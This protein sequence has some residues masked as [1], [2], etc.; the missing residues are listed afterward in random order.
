MSSVT[1]V[2]IDSDSAVILARIVST[3]ERLLGSNGGTC[4]VKI[5]PS[6]FLADC[7]AWMRSRQGQSWAIQVDGRAVGLI[8]ASHRELAEH[9]RVV[10]YWL[11]SDWWSQGIMTQALGQL[12]ERLKLAGVKRIMANGLTEPASIALW[13][14]LGAK[15]FRSG[16]GYRA[17]LNLLQ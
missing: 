1:L 12:V 15:I 6:Q 7:Q 10:G 4:L 13:R 16:G 9:E 5:S 14:R 3:D 17:R 8:S 2:K 11:G